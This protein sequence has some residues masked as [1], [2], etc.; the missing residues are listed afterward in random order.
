[1]TAVD[2]TERIRIRWLTLCAAAWGLAIGISLLGIWDKPAPPD[3]LPGLM[4]TLGKDAHASFR[5]M[6]GIVL[7]TIVAAF[8]MKPLVRTLAAT[9]TRAWARNG[10]AAAFLAGLWVAIVNR[11]LP[12]TVVPPLIAV[13]VFTALRRRRMAFT[14]RDAILIPVCATVFIALIDM[15]SLP[16][17]RAAILAVAIV[18]AI[19]LV[20]NVV[21]PGE[22]APRLPAGLCFAIAP[23]ALLTQ[24]GIFARDQRYSPWPALAIALLTPFVLRLA[25]RDSAV[26]R[27]RL[28]A[29][30][31]FVAYPI[32]AW[33]YMN[34]TSIITAEGKPRIDFFEDA[35]HVVA[36]GEMMRGERP[37][38]DIVP[39]HGFIQD[40]L[41]DY[42]TLRTGP[43]NMGRVQKVRGVL[44]GCN[45]IANY[46]LAAAATGSP[47][48]G[49]L[50][51]FLAAMIGSAG[52][53]FRVLPAL[54]ALACAAAGVRRRKPKL[55]AASAVFV[56]IAVLTSLDFGAYALF[57]L[58]FAIAV[59]GETKAEKLAALRSSAIAFGITS[60]IAAIAM[61]IGG[62]LFDFIRVTL[63]EVATLGPAYALPPWSAPPG[64]QMF[65]FFP[66]V[67]VAIFH[68]TTFLYVLWV[69]NLLALVVAI[70]TGLRGTSRRRA[71]THALMVISAFV[72]I[73]SISY[74]ERHHQHF[75]FVA[76]PLIVA[77][78]WRMWFARDR[79]VRIA[80][81]LATLF[82]IMIASPTIH[83]AISAAVRRTRGPLD[84]GWTVSAEPRTAGAWIRERDAA[85]VAAS[86]AY[87]DRTVGPD[88][89]FFDFT[90]RALLFFIL[91]RDCPIR[92][93]EPAFYETEALQREVI[94]RIENNPR[95]RAA[96]IPKGMDDH[97]GVDIP[98]Q[99][100]A[101]LVWRY[102]QE[103]FRPDYED[104]NVVFWRR[105]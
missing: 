16:V 47:H 20:L 97:T 5:F 26:A 32:A 83:I 15:S 39:P 44:A 40:G 35:Q 73:C 99:L 41:L 60:A 64:F 53:T 56:V 37:Y 84:A 100:R 87:V 91:D 2:S 14:R 63:F 68:R 102:L 11:D 70:V 77:A 103:H 52:G 71:A 88:G 18:V 24:T 89:T 42:L 93:I 92:Q 3:Q 27:R 33:G 19:R 49:I 54:I 96:L 31:T 9:D 81:G 17:D 101:P 90:N 62:F 22:A 4:T 74:A 43:A 105:K 29:F 6:A 66:E 7:M 23:I 98:N 36:A 55:L 38:K 13:V 57:A 82:V 59:F 25:V 61:L 21:P 65:R 69:V 79:L 78:L 80:A 76:G 8:G 34:A 50:A 28:R 58:A 94:A 45:A 75:Q 95:V 104:E 48:A 1:M 12:W 51:L 30:I 72:A 46:A 67:A 85:I 86:R 10:A